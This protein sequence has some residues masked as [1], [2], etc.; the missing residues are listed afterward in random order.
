M[1]NEDKAARYHRLQRRAA[2]A[3]TALGAALL[4][5]LLVSGWSASLRDAAA[6]LAGASSPLTLVFYVAALA[7]LAGL[8]QLPLA[9]YQGVTLERRYELSTESVGR[10]AL[11]RLKGSAVGLVFAVIAAAI[12]I[13]LLRAMPEWWWLA[14]AAVFSL[15]MIGLAHL[16]P[17]LLL[18]IFYTCTPLDRPQLVERLVR[19]ADRAGTRVLGVFELRM[20][21]RT[22]KANAALTGIGRTRRILLSDTLLEDYTDD[23]IEVILGHE[24]AHHVHRDI[25]KSMA[26]EA[27]LVTLGFYLADR[28]LEWAAG[29]FGLLDKGDVAALPVLL[30]AAGAVSMLLMP[31]A[32][33]LSRAHERAADRYAWEVTNNSDA[34]ISAMKRLGAQNLAEERP[35]RLVEI[36]FH[37]HPPMTA[38]IEAAR[39]WAR[40]RS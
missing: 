35:S 36:L 17:V 7:L 1:A 37:S 26:V 28:A 16:A 38:R 34:F 24:L 23:E 22:R 4:V 25:W 10:W 5:L 19:L 21:D 27:V 40:A 39:A 14:A 32:N 13:S 11:D 30:L 12:V 9:F 33:A 18:P 2:L 3:N 20:S 29:R 31:V 15:L 8:V 6:W